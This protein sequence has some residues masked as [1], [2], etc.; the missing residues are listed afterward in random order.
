[1]VLD[2]SGSSVGVG[3]SGGVGGAGVGGSGITLGMTVELNGSSGGVDSSGVAIGDVVGWMAMAV[4]AGALVAASG[5]LGWSAGVAAQA[6]RASSAAVS[7]ISKGRKI[8][9]RISTSEA[10]AGAGT[11]GNSFSLLREARS[12]TH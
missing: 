9:M 10:H 6:L 5:V 8:T 1:M 2:T 12:I 7:P 4:A 11:D 3:G